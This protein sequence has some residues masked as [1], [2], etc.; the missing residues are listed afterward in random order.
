MK[1]KG[2]LFCS[3]RELVLCAVCVIVSLGSICA[4]CPRNCFCPPMSNNV[5][6]SRGNLDII[7]DGIPFDTL[8]LTLNDNKFKNPVLTRRNFTNLSSLKNLYLSGCGIES[9]AIDTFSGLT[10]LKWLDISKNDLKFIPDFTFR[11]LNLENFF[12]NENPGIQFSSK[13]FA[14]LSTRGL[15][16]HNCALRNLSLE[17]LRPLNGSL[18][19]LWLYENQFEKLDKEWL[20]LLRSL[21]HVRLGKNNFH[22]NCELT[23]L[24]E[25]FVKE[26]SIF[27]GGDAPSCSSPPSH[28]NKLF[29]A[30]KAGDFTCELPTFKKVDAIFESELGKLTCTAS[31]DPSPTLYWIRPDGTTETY[32]PSKTQPKDSEGVMYITNPQLTDKSKYKCIANNPAGNVTFSL[33]LAWPIAKEKPMDSTTVGRTPTTSVNKVNTIEN[34]NTYEWTV[35]SK[36]EKNMGIVSTTDKVKQFSIVDIVGAVIGTFLL[37]LLIC[38]LVFHFYYRRRERLRYDDKRCCENKKHKN[39]YTMS[40]HDEN[41][42]KMMIQRNSEHIHS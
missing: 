28:R 14:G 6:C 23:W 37:T 8:E 1:R 24:Y 5:Y 36:A 41:C 4:T 40:D 2:E 30:L 31:G 20:Y 32:Y 25:F 9:I 7:P 15:Y 29:N 33:N 19:A 42:I 38:A 3:L 34:K 16:M 39:V 27:S 10:K 26:D 12:I 22:C 13:A 35:N 18:R 21:S 11:G 17:V